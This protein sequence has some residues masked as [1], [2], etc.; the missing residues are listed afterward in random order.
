MT[1]SA[2]VGSFLRDRR[3][4]I[5]GAAEGALMR[6]TEGHYRQAG[7]TEVHVRLEALFDHVADAVVRRDVVNLLG[8]T[9][10]L[11]RERFDDGYDLSEVQLAFNALEEATWICIFDEASAG[12]VAEILGLVTTALG[13]AKDTLGRTWVELATKQR[14]PT[15]DLRALFAGTER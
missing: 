5:V 11:A 4:T 7:Q 10:T 1:R 14:A 13:A 2:D 9:R 3:D 12:D 15:L 6:R 8:Y